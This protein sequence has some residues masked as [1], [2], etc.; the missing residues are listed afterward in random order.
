MIPGRTAVGERQ[1]AVRLGLSPAVAA[2]LFACAGPKDAAEPTPAGGAETAR[3]QAATRRPDGSYLLAAPVAVGAA[4]PAYELVLPAC[5][6]PACPARVRLVDGGRAIDSATV[7]W[8][9]VAQ[10]PQRS[11]QPAVVVGVGDPLQLRG[12]IATWLTGEGEDAIA[13]LAR[14]V[15]LEPAL[16]GLLVHQS[17]GAEHVKRLHYLFVGVGGK[18]VQAWRGWEGQGLTTSSVD[19]LD[20][21]GDG[22]SEILYWRFSSPDGVTRDWELSAHRWNAERR[23]LEAMPAGTPPVFAVVARSFPAAAAA[24]QFLADRL[25]CQGSFAVMRAPERGAS[26]FAVAAVTARRPLALL[27]ARECGGPDTRVVEIG[28]GRR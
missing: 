22:R 11:E 16:V 13:T 19:T 8:E 21:D 14:P 28:V 27:A 3:A 6:A 12:T 2:V 7:D 23:T 20:V 1:S 24:E 25:E 26:G 17:G 9:S 18:L 15:A 10:A 4:G 5:G